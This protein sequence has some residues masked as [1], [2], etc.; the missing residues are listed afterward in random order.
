[1]E[2]YNYDLIRTRVSRMFTDEDWVKLPFDKS[3]FDQAI[4]LGAPVYRLRHAVP[5]QAGSEGFDAEWGCALCDALE[6]AG[7]SDPDKLDQAIILRSYELQGLAKETNEPVYV[8]RNYFVVVVHMRNAK[9]VAISGVTVL[10]CNRPPK[11]LAQKV[12]AHA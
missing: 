12:F 6:N 8:P 10:D 2:R 11:I 9:M 5:L 4:C 1:M 3:F 7:E